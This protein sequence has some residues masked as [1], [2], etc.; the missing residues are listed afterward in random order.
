MKTTF[1]HWYFIAFGFF[2]RILHRVFGFRTM[3]LVIIILVCTITSCAAPS[4]ATTASVPTPSARAAATVNQPTQTGVAPAPSGANSPTPPPTL[5]PLAT[6]TIDNLA[7]DPDPNVLLVQTQSFG[8]FP[9]DRQCLVL[10]DL[11]VWEDGRVVRVMI[12]GDKREV[13]V[14]RLSP[15][16]VRQMLL[17]LKQHGAL[18]PLPSSSGPPNPGGFRFVFTV[19]LKA[20]PVEQSTFPALDFIPKLL[21]FLNADVQPLIPQQ[22]FLIVTGGGTSS[23]TLQELPARFNISL[24]QAMDKGVWIGG[25][26]LSFLWDDANNQLSQ[27]AFRQNGKMYTVAL[28]I[29]GVGPKEPPENCWAEWNKLLPRVEEITLDQARQ[30][31][32]FHLLEPGYLPTGFRLQ[33]VMHTTTVATFVDPANYLLPPVT[34]YF[35][36]VSLEYS[37]PPPTGR[38][39]SQGFVT[40]GERFFPDMPLPPGVPLPAATPDLHPETVT[41]R[42]ARALVNRYSAISPPDWVTPEPGVRAYIALGWHEPD[43]YFMIG[44]SVS[45][46]ELVKIA[47]SLK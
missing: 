29:T 23:E 19:Q 4:P 7:Y 2:D 10:P 28:E 14:G 36:S 47:N 6:S 8:P 17:F 32:G 25:D 46:E 22:A 31:P 15:D 43:Y 3:M 39:G 1:P 40:L 26:A 42:N 18:S 38:A 20:G 9:P 5:I 35:D 21:D 37:G 16:R 45:L 12:K 27:H 44:G 13:A 33:R 41:V 34:H 24:A 30:I 11:R